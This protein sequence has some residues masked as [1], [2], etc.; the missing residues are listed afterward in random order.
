M[1][2]LAQGQATAT[3]PDGVFT[4]AP[5]ARQGY[6]HV[7]DR[8]RTY[9]PY[10]P[11]STSCCDRY[12]L[13]LRPWNLYCQQS[14][15]ILRPDTAALKSI[16]ASR[17]QSWIHPCKFQEKQTGVL[18]RMKKGLLGLTGAERP[19]AWCTAVNEVREGTPARLKHWSAC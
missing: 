12:T 18:A 9:A 6:S 10:A 11:D 2:G 1:R 15:P 14:L 16:L 8:M 13:L 4:V 3:P 17:C 7:A 19:A 5:S